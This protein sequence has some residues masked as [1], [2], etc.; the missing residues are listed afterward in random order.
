M[1]APRAFVPRYGLET[2]RARSAYARAA[3]AVQPKAMR[4]PAVFSCARTSGDSGMAAPRAD[5]W[6][7]QGQAFAWRA[8]DFTQIPH[9]V[10]YVSWF[11]LKLHST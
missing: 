2:S 9:W 5:A 1:R 3:G 7:A 10:A 11:N 8:A 6:L 4:H